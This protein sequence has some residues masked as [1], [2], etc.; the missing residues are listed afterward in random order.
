MA[1][2]VVAATN[3]TEGDHMTLL[4]CIRDSMDMEA[5]SLL[6]DHM[7]TSNLEIPIGTL[8]NVVCYYYSIC[9]YLCMHIQFTHSN[10]QCSSHRTS[11]LFG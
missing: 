6:L 11:G 10:N 7:D 2:I 5:L 1:S 8:V 3:W 4:R 9:M